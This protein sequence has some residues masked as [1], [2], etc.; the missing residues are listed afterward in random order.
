[1]EDRMGLLDGILGGLLG[2]S[3]GSMGGMRMGAGSNPLLQIALQLLQQNGG[4]QG[5]LGKFQQAGYGD[6]AQS[7][8]GTGQNMP[9]DPGAL[10]QIFG[11]GQLGQIAAQLGMSRD[12]AAGQLAQTL[13]NVVDRMT[14][15]GELPAGH[16]D[17]VNQV[18][19]ALEQR[20]GR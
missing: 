15:D 9:I 14:P 7:W 4:L 19:A 13:P 11:Q 3:G 10:S 2:G 16:D 6:H 12:E 1:M 17:L 8:V 20:Q 5:V 18:L